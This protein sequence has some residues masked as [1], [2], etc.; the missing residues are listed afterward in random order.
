M[1]QENERS[2]RYYRLKAVGFNSREA[3][4]LKDHKEHKIRLY[5]HLKQKHNREMKELI[6]KGS[7]E[8]NDH[9]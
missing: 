5:I 3:N 8:Q 1:S 2:K 6:M 7:V 9:F 4:K